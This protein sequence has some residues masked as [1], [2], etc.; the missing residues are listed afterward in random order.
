MACAR[1]K[2]LCGKDRRK[3]FIAATERE[4][5]WRRLLL[6]GLDANRGK[7]IRVDKPTA[8]SEEDQPPVHPECE[9]QRERPQ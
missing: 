9:N 4:R 2:A 5:R 1:K 3:D 8:S 6:G 7:G